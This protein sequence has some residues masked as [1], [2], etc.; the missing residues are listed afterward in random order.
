MYDNAS[1]NQMAIP[2][3]PGCP[4][5]VVLLFKHIYL[6]A[7]NIFKQSI[8]YRGSIASVLKDLQ[9]LCCLSATLCV[10]SLTV[11]MNQEFMICSGMGTRVS[12]RSFMN[13]WYYL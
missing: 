7:Y 5:P 4:N 11:L 3:F 6:H 12:N 10:V 1:I 8:I 9:H 2:Y 13:S